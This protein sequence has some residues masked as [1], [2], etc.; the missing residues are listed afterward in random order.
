MVLLLRKPT[1]EQTAE[2]PVISDIRDAPVMFDYLSFQMLLY[3][4]T[5]TVA[6]GKHRSKFSYNCIDC[7]GMILMKDVNSVSYMYPI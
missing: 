6:T 5:F 2:L 3:L 1:F 4:S 7:A